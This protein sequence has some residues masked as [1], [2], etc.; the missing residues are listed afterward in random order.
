MLPRSLFSAST[1]KYGQSS[2]DRSVDIESHSSSSRAPY[3]RRSNIDDPVQTRLE[4]SSAKSPL[5]IDS[6]NEQY[7]SGESASLVGSSDD[8]D[9]STPSNLQGLMHHL[10]RL[11]AKQR[12]YIEK[13][14][15]ISRQMQ[16]TSAKIAE[17]TGMSLHHRP[18]SSSSSSSK[19]LRTDARSLKKTTSQPRASSSSAS[20]STP[21]VNQASTWKR[22]QL[23]KRTGAPQPLPAAKVPRNEYYQQEG[24]GASYHRSSRDGPQK[25]STPTARHGRIIKSESLSPSPEITPPPAE[26]QGDIKLRSRD[27]CDLYLHRNQDLKS[28]IFGKKPRSLIYNIAEGQGDLKDLMVT[29]SL[30]GDMQFWN[31]SKRNLVKTIGQESLYHDSWIEE[32]CWTT[33]NTLA[34]CNARAN[35]P[36]DKENATVSLLHLESGTNGDIKY[37]LQ[38]LEESPHTKPIVT[39]APVDLG[40]TGSA[41]VERATFVTG[42]NDKA[43]YFWDII[44]ESPHEDFALSDV[45]KLSI[46]HTNYVQTF[47]YDQTHRKL[48]TGGADCKMFTYDMV[49]QR[50]STEMKITSRINHILGN[51]VDPNLYM[52]LTASASNQFT[53]YDQRMPGM[54]GIVLDF[55]WKE[56]ENLSRYIRPDWHQNGYMVGCGSQSESKWS[57]S[58]TML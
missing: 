2:E 18:S 30:K 44:R 37:R 49:S 25:T 32:L 24:Q 23:A 6:E 51:A 12:L 9:N 40:A 33:K 46:N 21:A 14:Q 36:T 35:S 22:P 20:S 15:E 28:S 56:S 17:L 57:G 3:T 41:G 39:I 13:T 16:D 54:R 8:E 58:R 50:V 52:L 48:F 29:T 19:Y 42:G 43:V 45:S 1:L 31:A 5:T 10:S 38:H 47:C 55:G 34:L 7:F 26:D 27:T 53:I 4:G 11:Q